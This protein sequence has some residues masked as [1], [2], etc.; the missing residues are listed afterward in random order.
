LISTRLISAVFSAAFVI[1]L[2][3]SLSAQP[4]APS[5]IAVPLDAVAAIVDAFKSRSLV[6]LGE[7]YGHRERHEFLLSLIRPPIGT[8]LPGSSNARFSGE[9]DER[10]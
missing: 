7:T 5:K 8:A 10:Y 6:A 9:D 3:P 2:V 1:A 4:P